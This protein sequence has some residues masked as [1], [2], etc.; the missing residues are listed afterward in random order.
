MS[1]SGLA[2]GLRVKAWCNWLERWY[3]CWM[4]R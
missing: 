3:V 4:F 2:Y 1:S